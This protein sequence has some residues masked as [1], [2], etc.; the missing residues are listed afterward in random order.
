MVNAPHDP[1]ISPYD[2]FFLDGDQLVIG[3]WKILDSNCIF[4]SNISKLI[5]YYFFNVFLG[6]I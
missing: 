3:S 1:M 4:G 2:I 6:F 5:I